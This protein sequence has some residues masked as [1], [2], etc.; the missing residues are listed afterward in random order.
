[1]SRQT[2]ISIGL[3]VLFWIATIA[4]YVVSAWSYRDS[5][6]LAITYEFIFLPVRLA[7][8]YINWFILLPRL[9]YNHKIGL[10]LL[11]LLSMIILLAIF[12]RFFTI[13]WAYPTFFPEWVAQAKSTSI[14][15]RMAQHIVVITPPV[16]YSTVFRLFSDWYQQKNKTRQ[17]EKEKLDAELK[18]L[19]SQVNPH[20]LFNTLNNIY[21]LA[22]EKSDKVPDLILK[23]SEILSFSLYEANAPKIDLQ[24]ELTLI[25]NMISLEMD[26]YEKRVKLEIEL[27]PQTEGHKISPLLL[28]PLVENAFK[29]GV[30]NELDKAYISINGRLEKGVFFFCIRNTIANSMEIPN[31]KSGLGI[32]NLKKRLELLYPN[33]FNLSLSKNGNMFIAQLKL[34]LER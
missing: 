34:E 19:K 32:E 23:L 4:T 10:Y 17:L 6:S 16:A 33:K 7:A 27:P 3:H 31:G 25:K 9:L 20:F 5:F 13:Y 30:K 28:V 8:V 2:F 11:V 18:Y 21:G 24:Q 12:Q 26:R 1:M 15:T 22:R 29:H 14:L